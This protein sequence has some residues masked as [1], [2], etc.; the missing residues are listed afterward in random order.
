MI[1]SC[2]ISVHEL[3]RFI[4]EKSIELVEYI[5]ENKANEYRL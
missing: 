3:M 5:G 4:G 1:I 2:G